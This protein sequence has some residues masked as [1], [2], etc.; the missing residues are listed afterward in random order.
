MSQNERKVWRKKRE[1]ERVKITWS[2]L[3][4]DQN[5]RQE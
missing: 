1:R 4:R 3:N 5:E 2:F